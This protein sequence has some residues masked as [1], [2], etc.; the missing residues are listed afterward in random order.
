MI[1][2]ERFAALSDEEQDETVTLVPD[3]AVELVSKSQGY[4]KTR[5]GLF[6]K[7]VAMHGAN[8]RYTLLLD[9]YASGMDRVTAWGT[10]PPEFP[11]DWA[12]VLNA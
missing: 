12:E 1:L 9:P 4:G 2:T 7:C 5:G 8:V 10:P 3:V 6:P 11:T